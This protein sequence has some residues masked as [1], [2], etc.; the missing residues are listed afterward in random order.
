MG[1]NDSY[2]TTRGQILL[3]DPIPPMSKVFSLMSQEEKHR[4]VGMEISQLDQSSVMAM[5]VNEDSTSKEFTKKDKPYCSHCKILG[6]TVNKCFKIDGYPPGYTPRSKHQAS[7]AKVKQESSHKS[8]SINALTDEQCHQLI[9]MLSNRLTTSAS[10]PSSTVQMS[11][12][13]HM[14]QVFVVM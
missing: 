2:A 9:D 3:M 6:H 14:Q 10:T 13:H 12:L 7:S 8:A 11:T 1:L 5:A 4:A